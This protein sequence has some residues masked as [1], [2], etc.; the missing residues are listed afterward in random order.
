MDEFPVDRDSIAMRERI[1]LPLVVIQHY[2]LQKLQD[3]DES[4][5]QFKIYSKLITRTIYG[6]VNAG[7]NLA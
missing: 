2:S 5:P 1:I 6:I 4:D 3:M 7:R